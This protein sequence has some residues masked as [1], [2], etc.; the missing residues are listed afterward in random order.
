[1]QELMIKAFQTI[2]FSFLLVVGLMPFVKK[3]AYSVG[4]VDIP[5]KRK[6]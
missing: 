1:M 2:I 3:I 5:N 6:V 4:A